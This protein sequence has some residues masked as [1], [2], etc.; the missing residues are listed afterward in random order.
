MGVYEEEHGIHEKKIGSY[1][2][3]CKY[4]R[5]IDGYRWVDFMEE[6][7]FVEELLVSSAWNLKKKKKEG[8]KNQL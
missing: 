2:L 5:L 1:Q 6:L 7:P 3:N 8:D 4:T